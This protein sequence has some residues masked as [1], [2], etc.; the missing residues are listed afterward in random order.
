M[1]SLSCWFSLFK[2]T[3]TSLSS[4][5]LLPSENWN[6]FLSLSPWDIQPFLWTQPRREVSAV[7]CRWGSDQVLLSLYLL[8][9]TCSTAA[10]L[11]F[12][13]SL[14][15]LFSICGLPGMFCGEWGLSS[16]SGPCR[17][18]FFCTSGI[19]FSIHRAKKDV[20]K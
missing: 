19:E 8:I 15:I 16:P 12:P 2:R 20:K 18:G 10:L 3:K 1:L 6:Q 9:S 14:L 13:P 17:P 7:P 11:V 4:W 5:L